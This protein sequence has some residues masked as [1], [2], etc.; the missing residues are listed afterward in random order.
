[1]VG[2]AHAEGDRPQ[3]SYTRFPVE[4]P[5]GVIRVG[6]FGCSF[7][8]GSEAGEGFDFPSQLQRLFDAA[9]ATGVQVLNFGVGAYGLQQSYLLWGM[10]ATE[11]ALDY[12][13]FNLYGFHPQRDTTFVMNNHIY[14]PVHGRFIIDDGQLRLIRPV[15]DDRL[16]ASRGY[17]GL[18]PKWRY[19]RFDSKTAPQVRALL[20][21]GKGL[22]RNPFYY[23]QDTD[24]EIREIYGAIFEQMSQ[25]PG[26]LLVLCNNPNQFSYL[27]GHEKIGPRVWD[28]QTN[29]FAWRQRGVYL[30][31][32]NHLSAMGYGV[33]ARELFALL[34]TKEAANPP[35]LRLD[36]PTEVSSLERE[37]ALSSYDELLLTVD[38]G[39]FALFVEE[40][41]DSKAKILSFRERGI[42]SLIDVSNEHRLQFLALPD[43]LIDGAEVNLT[44]RKAGVPVVVPIG[45]IR[46]TTGV[47]GAVE[48]PWTEQPGRGWMLK[49][50][51]NATV[52]EIQIRTSE[53]TTDITVDVAGISVLHGVTG[54]RQP[55]GWAPVLLEPAGTPFLVVRGHPQ[56]NPDVVLN[57]S[58]GTIDLT[59]VSKDGKKTSFPMREYTI[60]RPAFKSPSHFPESIRWAE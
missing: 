34:T 16:E 19:L 33:M 8:R 28:C 4:K 35:I 53:E 48:L 7:V 57:N 32:G 44:F 59:L 38:G 1:M 29:R 20:P 30:A 17:F 15:G 56:Q 23:R 31:P 37:L 22:R 21:A 50:D 40:N 39:P 55:S 27:Y 14:A 42:A 58:P 5:Q 46:T 25:A 49:R 26:Q 3:S 11:F 2:T 10:L 60:E 45:S 52:F 54:D 47:L 18:L 41:Q 12:T 36:G 24:R 51:V 43:V 13:V 6:V 9:G